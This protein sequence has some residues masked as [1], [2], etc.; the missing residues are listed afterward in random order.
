MPRPWV[1]RCS[2]GGDV[3]RR[4]LDDP[5]SFVSDDSSAFGTGHWS[6]R[7][8]VVVV[9]VIVVVIVVVDDMLRGSTR[10]ICF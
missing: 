2:H 8:R 5:G 7:F 1:S 4:L 6:S 10:H 3:V 9:V